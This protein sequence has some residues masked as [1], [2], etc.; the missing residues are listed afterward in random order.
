MTPEEITEKNKQIATMLGWTRHNHAS[1]YTW[2]KPDK[3]DNHFFEAILQFDSDW[4]WLMEAFQFIEE[5]GYTTSVTG[6][7]VSIMILDGWGGKSITS[8]TGVDKKEAVFIAASD[9]AS[10]YNTKQ[11]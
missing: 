3:P 9:F 5:K 11:L 2:T 6:K 4:N 7:F 1:Y 10:L 8:Q